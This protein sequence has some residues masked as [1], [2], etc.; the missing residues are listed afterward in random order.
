MKSRLKLICPNTFWKVQFNLPRQNK[1]GTPIPRC[2]YPISV[3]TQ[4]FPLLPPV[5]REPIVCWALVSERPY[6]ENGED[7]ERYI[8]GQV[9]IDKGSEIGGIN[10][11]KVY[12]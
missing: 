1:K 7:E 4:V 3:H 10:D 6:V 8:E 2:V 11:T 9:L 12:L 5:L